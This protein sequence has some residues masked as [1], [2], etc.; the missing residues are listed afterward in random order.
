MQQ[1]SACLVFFRYLG[2]IAA[3][4]PAWPCRGLPYEAP[5]VDGILCVRGS[6]ELRAD[7]VPIG[8]VCELSLDGK[9]RMGCR[10]DGAYLGKPMQESEQSDG[11]STVGTDGR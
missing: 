4:D 3:V 10:V 7:E 1:T 9:W 11:A 2:G 8:A 6:R 5:N